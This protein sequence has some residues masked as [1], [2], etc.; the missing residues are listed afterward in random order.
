M[1][2][3]I[4]F[5]A[6]FLLICVGG[7]LFFMCVALPSFT[8]EMQNIYKYENKREKFIEYIFGVDMDTVRQMKK[9]EPAKF[10]EIMERKMAEK[11]ITNENFEEVFS[12]FKVNTSESKFDIEN[13]IDNL[14]DA[15]K[16]NLVFDNRI[17][18]VGKAI[19]KGVKE[20]D[21]L[22]KDL[23]N[24]DIKINDLKEKVKLSLQ[25]GEEELSKKFLMEQKECELE[26]VKIKL[27]I[28]ELNENIVN[29]KNIEFDLKSN[30]KK[31]YDILSNYKK[32]S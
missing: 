5:K 7:V 29:L 28:D 14:L 32:E 1:N 13:N 19:E 9:K 16:S 18:E 24:I 11:N 25:N 17:E 30:Q 21:K 15:K 8:S 31:I 27:C 20:S 3:I 23:D 26:Y 6:I 2:Q 22:K 12:N 4:L 10:Y